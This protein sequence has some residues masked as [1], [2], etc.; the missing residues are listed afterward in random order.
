MSR[1]KAALAIAAPTNSGR[2]T[3]DSNA[4]ARIDSVGMCLPWSVDRA[5]LS[6]TPAST[7]FIIFPPHNLLGRTI[8]V[9][10]LATV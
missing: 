1:G 8:L 7:G 2:I 6:A 3:G 9:H 4:R 10:R 5:A